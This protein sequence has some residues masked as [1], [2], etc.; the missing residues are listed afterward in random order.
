MTDQ[1][2]QTD[3]Q[4]QSV[5]PLVLM[6]LDGWGHREA[7]EDNAISRAETPRWDQLLSSGTH[8]TIETSG[9]FVG[10]PAGQMGNSEVGHM[11]IG[12][13]RIVFQDFTRIGN[14]VE[15]GSFT[16]NPVLVNAI[17][18][19]REQA[20]TLHIMGLLSPG[21]V[22]SHEDQFLAMV[23]MAANQGAHS[24]KVHAFL[25][26]RDTPPRSAGHSIQM[27]QECVDKLEHTEIASICG[28]YYAMDRDQRWDRVEKAWTML[29]DA[30]AAFHYDK[31]DRALEAAYERDESDEFVNPTIIG[32][33][34]GVKDGDV[35]I[36]I[37][38]RADRAR[39]ITR[40]FCQP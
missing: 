37:N 39:E 13:G 27:M 35:V 38:F 2:A 8:T 23:R 6:I 9:E 5:E 3:N 24:I 15:D 29:V 21:G 1:Q 26:G 18:A 14:A 25:D 10:L 4:H 17:T 12:A 33:Y 22:H 11:N 32:S 34:A 36:F 40:A 16:T 19:S 28:R 30:K 7:A 31:A 20:S